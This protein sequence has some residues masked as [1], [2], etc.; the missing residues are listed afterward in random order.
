MKS[1]VQSWRQLP[2]L[3]THEQ[4]GRLKSKVTAGPPQPPLQVSLAFDHEASGAPSSHVQL[5]K[6]AGTLVPSG[7]A[8]PPPTPPPPLA[9]PIP[10]EPFPAVPDELSMEAGLHP[11]QA[12]MAKDNAKPTLVV[13]GEE[14]CPSIMAFSE[15]CRRTA[16]QLATML[17]TLRRPMGPA[18]RGPGLRRYRQDCS[19]SESKENG[20]A[21][22]AVG[23]VPPVTGKLLLPLFT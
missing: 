20:P 1:R 19:S 5:G 18:Q 14:A 23:T 6:G 11:T 16:I 21:P 7:V 22:Y 10:P 4:G 17:L 8:S 3:R 2:P 12:N 13:F 9:P 15:S